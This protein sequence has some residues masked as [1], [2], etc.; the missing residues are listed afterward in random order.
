MSFIHG[1]TRCSCDAPLEE[2]I[3]FSLYGGLFATIF[4]YVE[5]FLLHLFFDVG[6]G[7][8]FGGLFATFSLRKGL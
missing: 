7:S 3:F 5:T 4:V 1:R 8:S 2:T 6:G